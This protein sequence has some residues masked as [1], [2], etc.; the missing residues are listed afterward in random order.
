MELNIEKNVPVWT[1]MNKMVTEELEIDSYIM[2]HIESAAAELNMTEN[3]VILHI[4]KD[5]MSKVVNV[6]EAKE[7]FNG[8]AEAGRY[9]VTGNEDK[10]LAYVQIL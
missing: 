4:L 7:L 6:Q 10:P 9:I 3:E 1:P 8:K 2:N 5:A